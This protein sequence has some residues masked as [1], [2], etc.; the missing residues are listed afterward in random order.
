MD[1]FINGINVDCDKEFVNKKKVVSSKTFVQ[2]NMRAKIPSMSVNNKTLKSNVK[3]LKDI[4]NN[5]IEDVN[6]PFN[7]WRVNI[8]SWSDIDKNTYM[9]WGDHHVKVR[10]SNALESLGCITDVEL[11]EADITIYLFGSP[12]HY[13]EKKPYMYNPLSYNVCWFYSHPEKMNPIEASK[14]DC[15]FCL[16]EPY[17][18]N[19]KNYHNNISDDALLGCTDF[20]EPKAIEYGSSGKMSMVANARGDG[21]PYGRI[22]VKY[23]HEI[24]GNEP[25]IKIWGHKWLLPK[26][27]G[28]PNSWYVDKYYDYNLLPILYKE[29]T[30]V[31][32]DGHAEMEK[33]GFVPVKLFDVF[34]SGGMPIIKYN[35]GIKNIFGDHVLQYTDAV[36]LK[37]CI[38]ILDDKKRCEGI[39][40]Q[41]QKIA[42]KYTYK[43]NAMKIL[44]FVKQSVL[45]TD[46][47]RH[48]S[49]KIS[50]NKN[51]QSS[52]SK[53]VLVIGD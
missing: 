29:S 11:H 21:A 7:G 10:L 46:D 5:T 48:K 8:V 50:E 43:Y 24:F 16:S 41:G 42:L 34:A 20:K 32:I 36:S 18:D 26:Y 39:I 51:S 1:K 19:I 15:I 33:H 52:L 35:K 38:D 17:L 14:F 12:F 4:I 45:H 28:F 53:R 23:L 44:D 49:R 30:A 40:K 31:I 37:K 13:R 47:I 27:T 6:L 9:C 22:V 3:S 2:N 25:V